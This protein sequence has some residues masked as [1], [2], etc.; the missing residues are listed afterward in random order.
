[1]VTVDLKGVHKVQS[2]GRHYYYAWRG[3]PRLPGKP[4]TEEFMASYFEALESRNVPSSSRFGALVRAYRTSPEYAKLAD[5]TKRNWSRMLDKIDAHFGDI[6]IAQFDRPKRIRPTILQWRSQFADTPRTAD[7]GMQVLSRVLS[8]AVDPLGK[9]AANPCEGIRNLYKNDRA[10]IIWTEHD[11]AALK[12]AKDGKGKPAC[13]TEMAWAIDLA[14][15]TGLRVGDLV[16]ATWSHVG[17][18]AIIM[19]TSKSKGKREA[20]IP[21]YDDLRSLLSRIPRRSNTI[22]TNSRGTAWTQDGLASSFHTAKRHAGLNDRN[23]HFHDLRGTAATKFYT[24]GLPQRVIAE[25]MGWS[26]DEVQGIIRR[27]VDRTA[28][29]RAVIDRIN[30]GVKLSVK[31]GVNPLAKSGHKPLKRLMER[32]TGIEP[33]FSAWEAAALPLSYTRARSDESNSS[34]EVSSRMEYKGAR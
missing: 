16:K 29:T 24:L 12:D 5:S 26:E 30:A 18:D 21:L 23:L 34:A 28:A 25:I 33:A 20:L 19:A 3:G 13:S 22:L 8:Y 15:Y 6:S 4:G 27:Y 10:A 17:Q 9:V 14:I 11:I 1:M 2:K 32:E 7:Y 31:Q